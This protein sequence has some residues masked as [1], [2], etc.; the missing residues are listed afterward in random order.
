M[1]RQVWA[2]AE[3]FITIWREVNGVKSGD[4]LLTAKYVRDVSLSER[5]NIVRK[6]Q[7]GVGFDSTVV[8][9]V[10]TSFRLSKDYLSKVETTSITNFQYQYQIEIDLVNPL[11]DGITQVD[12]SIGLYTCTIT[13]K[14]ISAQDNEVFDEEVV[15]DV[16]EVK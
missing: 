8:N 5:P 7:P 9:G 12:D 11:Y 6:Q 1:K 15:Y 4:A 2:L 14:G 16:R 10:Q 13:T 3:A